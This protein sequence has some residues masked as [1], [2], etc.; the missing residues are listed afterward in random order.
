M[1]APGILPCIMREANAGATL[2]KLLESV[3]GSLPHHRED[4][5]GNFLIVF[6]SELLVIN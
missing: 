4:F 5:V 3:S 1:T 6:E 2:S